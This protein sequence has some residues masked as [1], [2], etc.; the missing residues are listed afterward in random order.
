VTSYTITSATQLDDQN[1]TVAVDFTRRGK[2]YHAQYSMKKVNG[3][4]KIEQAQ[5]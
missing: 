5:Q 3:S 4:W 2:V 1:A